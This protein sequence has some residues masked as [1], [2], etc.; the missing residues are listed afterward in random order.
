MAK[1]SPSC[2]KITAKISISSIDLSFE[3][4]MARALILNTNSSG[5]IIASPPINY[6]KIIKQ[7]ACMEKFLL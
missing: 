3:I 2:E 5:Q 6:M 1:V 7:H 4:A